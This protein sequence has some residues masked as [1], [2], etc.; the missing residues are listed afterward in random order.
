MWDFLLFRI[1]L[2]VLRLLTSLPSD[3]LKTMLAV[4]PIHPGS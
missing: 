1:Q 2:I 4:N 3:S